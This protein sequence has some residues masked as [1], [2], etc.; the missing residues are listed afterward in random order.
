VA[1][2]CPPFAAGAAHVSHF[3][4]RGVRPQAAGRSEQG[5]RVWGLGFRDW[6]FERRVSGFVIRDLYLGFRV[7]GL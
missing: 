3:G 2:E 7:W 4:Q 6:G 1:H 5:S